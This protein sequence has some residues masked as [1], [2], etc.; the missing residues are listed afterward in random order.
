MNG[1]TMFTASRAILPDRRTTK[2]CI[3]AVIINP[4]ND[5]LTAQIP[6]SEVQWMDQLP[7]ERGR[8][9]G[10]ADVRQGDSVYD[11]TLVINLLCGCS[12]KNLVSFWKV[13]R[14]EIS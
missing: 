3:K 10:H 8:A 14:L 12:F 2:T 1:C 5:H 6:R 4:R 11:L 9:D 7:L 13:K